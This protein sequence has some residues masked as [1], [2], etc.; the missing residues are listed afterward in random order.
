M[1]V[2]RSIQS[3][4]AGIKF[5]YVR[6]ENELLCMFEGGSSWVFSVESLQDFLRAAIEVI[7]E[8]RQANS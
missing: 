7:N 4:G 2:T 6:G 3:L 1:S 8:G 5:V